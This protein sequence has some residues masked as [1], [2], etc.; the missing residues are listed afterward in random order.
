MRLL[1]ASRWNSWKGY[2]TLINAWGSVGLNKS[3]TVLGGPPPSGESTDVPALVSQLPNAEAVCI[4]GQVDDI[5]AYIDQADIVIIP[6]DAPE[7]FGLVAIEAFARGRPVIASNGGGLAKI[8]DHGRTGWLFEMRDH[9]QLAQIIDE[10]TI[11]EVTS[12][13]KNARSSY[14]MDYT[15]AVF[16]DRIEKVLTKTNVRRPKRRALRCNSR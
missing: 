3:L 15:E 16:I 8:V 6:S 4:V 10:L 5:G 13:G 2:A 12:A 11:P 1:V 9:R 7:P 14:E